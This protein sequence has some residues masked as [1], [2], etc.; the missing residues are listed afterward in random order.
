M[1]KCILSFGE[2][3]WDLLPTG[4]VL[5]GA[6]L[7]FAY[8]AHT[9]GC[10][11]L[12]VSSL[13]TDLLGSQA[14]TGVAILGL[15]TSLIQWDGQHPTGTVKVTIE[16]NNQPDYL[17]TPEV[18]YDYIVLDEL[19][20]QEAEGADC[21]YF[22]TLA[23]RGK[24][25]SQT[26]KRL[27]EFGVNSLK[28][29]DLNLRKNCYSMDSIRF[30]LEQA[31]L[32]KLNESEVFLLCD[33]FNYRQKTILEII[34]QLIAKW[35]LKCCVATLG[36]RGA[37]ACLQNGEQ[38]YVPGYR[39]PVVDAVGAGDA[40]SAGFIHRYLDG[41]ALRECCELGNI[42]GALVSQRSG[43]TAPVTQKEIASFT[44]MSHERIIDPGLTK[45]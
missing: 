36:E 15:D 1:K 44:R 32:L 8:R 27:L 17:I 21:L 13:G 10:K 5:G 12:I 4:A 40:F 43:G 24:R 6:P 38:T 33:I 39:V 11:S 20:V 37:F 2:I 25:S 28:F 30:S 14:F 35:S 42:L 19:L 16:Q 26:I 23:Q 31:D 45:K 22:G 3:L 18:A 9:L 34:T 41:A 7:N 29:L